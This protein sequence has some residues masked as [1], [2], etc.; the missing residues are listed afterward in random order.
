MWWREFCFVW[1]RIG[2]AAWCDQNG[3]TAAFRQLMRSLE[4]GPS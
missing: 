2:Y 4:A 1:C 3:I